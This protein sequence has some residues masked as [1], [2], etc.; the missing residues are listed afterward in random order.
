MGRKIL[1]SESQINRLVENLEEEAAGYDDFNVM[2][3]HGGKSI[4][5][6]VDTSQDLSSIFK[7]ILSMLMSENIEYIDLKENL[8]EAIDLIEEVNMLTKIVFRDFTDKKTIMKGKIMH[9]KLESYQEKI[10]TLVGMGEE[11]LDRESLMERLYDLTDD[12]LNYVRDYTVTLL[13]ANKTLMG[14]LEKGKSNRKSDM[15]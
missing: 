8:I 5:M 2:G 6:L 12:V 9:R 1:L 15:N 4:T 11:I 10:R 7:G 3:Q 14:R 13:N